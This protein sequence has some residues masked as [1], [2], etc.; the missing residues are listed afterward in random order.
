MD[1]SEFVKYILSIG[2]KYNDD[3]NEFN[4]NTFN[5][6]YTIEI[7]DNKYLFAKGDDWFLYNYND[8]FDLC[9]I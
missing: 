1:Y 9:L 3:F 4:Y 6:N 2:F 5:I 8:L 7:G